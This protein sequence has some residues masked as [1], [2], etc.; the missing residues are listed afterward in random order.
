MSKGSRD[1]IELNRFDF[2]EH[3]RSLAEDWQLAPDAPRELRWL[4]ESLADVEPSGDRRQVSGATF[5]Q[6]GYVVR[7]LGLNREDARGFYEWCKKAQIT[8]LHCGHWVKVLKEGQAL[9]AELEQLVGER[10]DA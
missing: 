6:L 5:K 2:E 7:L 9:A 3:T 1:R 4:L 10:T 8:S